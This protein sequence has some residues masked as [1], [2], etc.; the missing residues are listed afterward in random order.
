M[1]RALAE[2]PVLD[3]RSNVED[4][5]VAEDPQASRPEEEPDPVEE[6]TDEEKQMQ[7]IFRDWAKQRGAA[8]K[9]T[10]RMSKSAAASYMRR[11]D[12]GLVKTLTKKYDIS[13]EELDRIE[14]YGAARDWWERE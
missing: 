4:P 12:Q 13:H 3:A 7:V 10:S 2:Y 9:K 8:L 6:L 1:A 11:R 14:A 5:P